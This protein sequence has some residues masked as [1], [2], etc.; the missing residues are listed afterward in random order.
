M[1]NAPKNL[2][3]IAQ[4]GAHTFD[5]A[6]LDR[7][8]GAPIQPSRNDDPLDTFNPLIP[9]QDDPADFVTPTVMI[10]NQATE[11]F[12]APPGAYNA[13]AISGLTYGGTTGKFLVDLTGSNTRKSIDLVGERWAL[14]WDTQINGSDFRTWEFFTVLSD[15]DAIFG[16]GSAYADEDIV[17]TR[18]GFGFADLGF[19]TQEEYDD[20]V[21]AMNLRVSAG[22]DTLTQRDFN[23]HTETLQKYDGTDDDSLDLRGWP[24]IEVT[25]VTEDGVALDASEY[26]LKKTP[27]VPNGTDAVGILERRPNN[28]TT[29][30]P[31]GADWERYAVTYSWGY[32]EPPLDIRKVAEDALVAGLMALSAG[33][34]A[35]GATSYAMDGFSVAYDRDML[36]GAMTPEADAILARYRVVRLG[37]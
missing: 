10:W 23:A 3:I 13:P 36:R 11:T 6:F 27:A 5:V 31:R 12:S 24:V 8:G 14:V 9:A 37:G 30:W 28:G 4:N 34:E 20:Y 16:A 25:Q 7:P 19:S 29:G 26:R 21:H 15:G 2:E 1:T 35:P 18:A 33:L 32:T 22:I 17:K